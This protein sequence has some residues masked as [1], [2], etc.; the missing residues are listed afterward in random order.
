MTHRWR[1]ALLLFGSGASALIYE[2]VW[3]RQFRLIFGASTPASAA[4]ITVFIGGL[5]LG[6]ALLGS[7]AD[8]SRNPLTM[9]A[10]LELGVT[11]C[12]ALTPILFWI[13]R[14][15]YLTVGGSFAIGMIPATALRLL[16]AVLVLGA[17]TF[18]MGGTLPAASRAVER[19]GDSSRSGVAVLYALNTGGAV[20]GAML[21]TFLLLERLGNLRT[22]FAACGLNA[23]V[24]VTALLIASSVRSP[25]K[26]S[27]ILR[28]EIEDSPAGEE[29][30]GVALVAAP[31]FVFAA[32]A[33]VG[34]AF[35]LMEL[36]WY[37]M[38][39]PLLGG[40]T[41]TFGLILGVALFGIG[42]GSFAYATGRRQRAS[43]TGFA[44]CSALEALA[45][46]VPFAVGDRVALFALFTRQLGSIGFSGYV[47]SW[48]LVAGFVVFPAAFASGVQFPLLISLLGEGRANVG[49]H[50]GRAYAWNTVGSILGSLAGG[51]GFLPF[52]TAQG[53]WRLAVGVLITLVIATLIQAKRPG[54]AAVPV[55]ITAVAAVALLFSEG[56]TAFW[57]Q[58][59]IGAGRADQAKMNPNK[60]IDFMHTRQR[61]TFW[62]ADGLE[63]SVSVADSD[64]FAFV[65]NG[66]GDGHA[67]LDA[68]T[69][70][71]GAVLA[72]LLHPHPRTAVVVG[73]G[74]GTTA[75][76]LAALPGMQHVDVVEIEPA[77]RHVAELCTPVNR[78]VLHD[79]KVTVVLGDGREFLL[80]HRGQYDVISAE[81]SNPYRAGIASLFTSE[82]YRACRTRLAP[83]GMFIQFLQAYEVDAATIR[84]VYATITSVFPHVETWQSQHGDLLLVGSLAPIP[85]DTATIAS[86]LR[87]PVVSRGVWNAWWAAEP[88]AVLAHY[89]GGDRSARTLAAGVPKNSDDRTFIEY[90]FARTLGNN[91]SFD[92][93]DL[94]AFARLES[95]SLPSC[96]T[97]PRDV[98]TIERRRMTMGIPDVSEAKVGSFLNNEPRLVGI[99]ASAYVT[100]D[101]NTVWTLWQSL[102]DP[103]TPLEAVMYADALARRGDPS[104]EP[105]IE[106]L[107]AVA[108]TEADVLLSEL[109]FR[110]GNVAASA[111]A[112]TAAF[113]AYRR[114]PWP[115][116][117]VMNRAIVVAADMARQ[118]GFEPVLP[119][120]AEALSQPFAIHMFE[121]FR[122]SAL[123]L[124]LKQTSPPWG[125]SEQEMQIIH[126]YEPHVPWQEPY[127]ARRAQC[128]EQGHLAASPD[129]ARDLQQFL[130]AAPKRLTQ[131]TT[132][133]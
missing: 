105:L 122:K 41:F 111:A 43:L 103:T 92:I 2:T 16:L 86:R 109:R 18:L 75:G 9:Y 45:L 63:S 5:G 81:P 33:V 127:L 61:T 129:A 26:R 117:I 113:H 120:I 3:L 88:M 104:A 108:P 119:Q 87:S 106:R 115:L 91:D 13:V 130:A 133:Q 22:L 4:V 99:A 128:Y 124:V 52:L 7:R 84:T 125:C 11:I 66:K 126:D 27:R 40:T 50:V 97:D 67:R 100:A 19:S 89:V 132:V 118:P 24:G 71:M 77:I 83:G 10:L 34:F 30:E 35:L 8:R 73:L 96:I 31:G 70:I 98:A 80:T 94:R 102:G 17:P 14:A 42:C 121:E 65:I 69:Q 53:T 38:L 1:V 54:I 49:R 72:G 39:A 90:S 46:A 107:R 36:V 48:C 55:A 93:A 116:P 23:L 20:V 15:G 85:Y 76:W 25:G 47:L 62:E 82:F 110:Q 21:A 78:D 12:A 101:Y 58:T 74:T 112:L 68:G 123:F 64:G 51:F 79:P 28:D 37:R 29:S 44:L 60:V 59:P 57:R 95:D 32:A 114:D 56:P 6:G 131:S